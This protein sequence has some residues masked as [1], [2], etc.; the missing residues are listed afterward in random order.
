MSINIVIRELSTIDD[1]KKAE[2]LQRLVWDDPSTVIYPHMLISFARSG[3]SMLGAFD[4]DELVGF[5]LGYLGL[6]SPTSDRP[7]MTNLKLVSQRMAVMPAYRDAGIGYEL[8]LAQ[9]RYAI[10]RGIR[11]I[12]WTFDPLISRNAYLNIHKL[13]AIVRDY[14]R[15]FYGTEVGPL[16]H[17]GSSD[18]ALV[19]WWVTNNRV[20]ERIHRRR[21]PLTL[22]QYVDSSV[23]IVNPTQPASRGYLQPSET[24]TMPPSQLAMVEI[25]DNISDIRDDDPD[26]AIAWQKHLRET[27][28]NLITAGFIITDFVRGEHEGR[29]RT[30]YV[31]SHKDAVLSRIVGSSS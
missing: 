14:T 26:L 31:V 12:T 30:Y 6:E 5:L 11:L 19:E 21:P 2:A 3:A 18:R 16:T 15:D 25:P 13:G 17:F 10:R 8:K 27:L 24:I 20:E 28:E 22:A 1:M 4:G 9:R 29:V 23:M 7:A